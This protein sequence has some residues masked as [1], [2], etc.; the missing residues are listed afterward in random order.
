MCE[1]HGFQPVL[2]QGANFVNQVLCHASTGAFA[3]QLLISDQSRDQKRSLGLYGACFLG[4]TKKTT[5]QVSLLSDRPGVL[6]TASLPSAHKCLQSASGVAEAPAAQAAKRSHYI[7][8]RVAQA[9]M[10]LLKR[11]CEGEPD[12]SHLHELCCLGV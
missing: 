3:H 6:T 11:Q 1:L 5:S 12:G 7:K 8:E 4:I 10:P 2:I 9:H